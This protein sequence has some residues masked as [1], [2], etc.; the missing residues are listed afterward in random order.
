MVL[1]HK[2]ELGQKGKAVNRQ[3]GAHREEM[4]ALGGITQVKCRYFGRIQHR[5]LLMSLSDITGQR[6]LLLKELPGESSQDTQRPNPS[7]AYC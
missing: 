7:S 1:I 2:T 3:A 5:G 4:S 6:V